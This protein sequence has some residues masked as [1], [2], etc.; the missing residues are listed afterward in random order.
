MN[1][2][3]GALDLGPDIPI[4]RLM[5][6]GGFWVQ[7]MPPIT[8]WNGRKDEK[9]ETARNYYFLRVDANYAD[10]SKEI[11]MPCGVILLSTAIAGINGIG[12]HGVALRYIKTGQ[13]YYFLNGNVQMAKATFI[14]AF[15][16]SID[17]KVLGLD[18]RTQ[19]TGDLRLGLSIG[20][21]VPNNPDQFIVICHYLALELYPAK[22]RI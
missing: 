16:N 13:R 14:L 11:D 8:I 22:S 9:Y 18:L 19:Q 5:E 2:D 10:C 17:G 15:P 20:G 4:T 21:K 3:L 1:N 12:I 6:T 7:S